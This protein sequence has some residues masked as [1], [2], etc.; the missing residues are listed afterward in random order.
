MKTIL[1]ATFVVL[2][3]STEALGGSGTVK[4]SVGT[5]T[6][7][8]V[9]F[10][11]PESIKDIGGGYTISTSADG[12]DKTT[13]DF[14]TESTFQLNDD[15]TVSINSAA[16]TLATGAKAFGMMAALTQTYPTENGYRSSVFQTHS[17]TVM[18][19]LFVIEQI[20]GSAASGDTSG[21]YNRNIVSI[22]DEIFNFAAKS[23]TKGDTLTEETYDQAISTLPGFAWENG[24][25]YI[26]SIDECGMDYT[27]TLSTNSVL[28]VD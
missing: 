18:P 19:Y 4:T 7:T 25:D 14:E 21:G 24:F 17:C 28:L 10:K 12:E 16:T 5:I 9:F 20:A 6:Q 15:R 23:D 3:L 26:N 1:V 27:G 2:L 11:P 22:G 13:L 8:N